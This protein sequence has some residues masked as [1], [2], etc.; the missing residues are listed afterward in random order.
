M[1]ILTHRFDPTSDKVVD[2]LNQRGVD[3]FRVDTSEFPEQLG[4]A[5][6]LHDGQWSGWMRTERRCL[7]LSAVSGI[8]YRRPTG[9]TFHPDMSDNERRWAAVQARMGLGGL[10]ATMRPWLNHPHMIGF[11]EYKP[12]QLRA[13]AASG[14]NVA[15]TTVTNDAGAARA[16]V[17]EVGR[18]IYKPFGGSGVYDEDGIRQVFCTVVDPADCDDPSI[19]RTMHLFQQWI[20][21]AY[22]VR[23]TVVDDQLF[24]ARIDGGSDAARIDW[25]TDYDNLTYTIVDTPDHVVRGVRA[26]LAAL[27]L[28]FG[29]LDFVVSPDGSWWFL[30]CNPNGQWAWIEDETGL[31]IAAAL[32]D[33]LQGRQTTHAA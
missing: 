27:G 25:R 10:L 15:P 28:R 29:A 21:K 30:E 19:A 13:A 32:A 11:A 23:L 6:T 26:L 14:L 5:A 9:F 16:F 17:T 7:D 2:E 20:P 22:E 3:L 31:P 33:A 18:A 24:A 1:V 8:Y 12:V 4:V